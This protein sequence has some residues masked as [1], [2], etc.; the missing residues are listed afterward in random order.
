MFWIESCAKQQVLNR[1]PVRGKGVCSD[2][3]RRA[4]QLQ[5][6]GRKSLETMSGMILNRLQPKFAAK[7]VANEMWCLKVG[8]SDQ[9]WHDKLRFLIWRFLEQ[10]A[11]FCRCKHSSGYC[12][13]DQLSI[14]QSRRSVL[15]FKLSVLTFSRWMSCSMSIEEK[16]CQ[17]KIFQLQS[18]S[19]VI[20][21]ID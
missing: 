9:R 16:L 13:T 3:T 18:M 11:R 1:R 6:A 14:T 20:R 7:S 2:S 8:D 21:C 19:N 12:F 5:M 15:N 4:H 10:S 17:V